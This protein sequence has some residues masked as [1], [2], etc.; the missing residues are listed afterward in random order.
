MVFLISPAF[1]NAILDACSA[2]LFKTLPHHSGS[3]RSGL[4]NSGHK[5]SV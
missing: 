1:G 2:D 4:A 5:S 3:V